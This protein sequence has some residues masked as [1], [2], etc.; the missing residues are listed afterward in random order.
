MTNSNSSL[1]ERTEQFSKLDKG[2]EIST[3]KLM[4]SKRC[5][6]MSFIKPGTET[7]IVFEVRAAKGFERIVIALCTKKGYHGM[8]EVFGED[9]IPVLSKNNETNTNVVKNVDATGSLTLEFKEVGVGSQEVGNVVKGTPKMGKA[10]VVYDTMMTSKWEFI[11]AVGHNRRVKDF[12][13][14][15]DVN[16]WPTA[17]GHKNEWGENVTNCH[18]ITEKTNLMRLTHDE[19]EFKRFHQTAKK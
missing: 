14:E 19:Q 3:E 9:T 18:D 4:D 13:I 17:L 5:T 6:G 2:D 15:A 8:V 10:G 12:I 16:H 11:M 7:C 1:N